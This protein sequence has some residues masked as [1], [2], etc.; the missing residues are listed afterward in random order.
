MRLDLSTAETGGRCSCVPLHAEKAVSD[1]SI[2]LRFALRRAT[3]QMPHRYTVRSISRISSMCFSR[4]RTGGIPVNA[5][6]RKIRVAIIVAP[7]FEEPEMTEPRKFLEQQG[8]ET[9]LI[10]LERGEVQAMKHDEK[11]RKYPVDKVLSEVSHEDFDALLLPGG[12]LNAD[13][14][15][16]E[17]SA[18]KF[19]RGMNE[20]GKP[21]AVI[22]HA[23][24]LLVSAGLV[25]GRKLTSYHTIQ[26]DIKNAGGEW[27]DT[28]A[29]VDKNWV[30][31]RKPDDIP[32]FNE[33]MKKL[34]WGNEAQ[35][36]RSKAAGR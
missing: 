16:V 4:I 7:D 6:S 27:S 29:V 1:S 12:A 26:D 36:R 19:V 2:E 10:S 25:R 23:P 20:T 33:E 24:W 21:M 18:Q 31:S 15:R 14:L 9:V 11:S 32:V 22:C 13:R 35:S 30:T 28:A 8:A 5:D 17:K 34:F 3:S